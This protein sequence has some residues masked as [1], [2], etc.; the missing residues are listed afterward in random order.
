MTPRTRT[1]LATLIVAA[2]MCLARPALAAEEK[3]SATLTLEAKSVAVGI[4][5]TW[6]GGILRYAGKKHRFKV[7]GLTVNGV[8]VERAEA[9]GNVY[10]LKKLSEFPG[11]YTAVEAGGAAGAGAAIAT[12]RNQHGVRITLHTTS[13]GISAEAGP[14]GIKITLED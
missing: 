6:G 14:E 7:E 3:P 4:G 13:Q 9:T 10:N 12:M 5:W 1:A 8:G 11:T 2:A